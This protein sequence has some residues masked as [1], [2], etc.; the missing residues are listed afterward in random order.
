MAVSSS[1]PLTYTTDAEILSHMCVST[2]RHQLHLDRLPAPALARLMAEELRGMRVLSL[3][4][5]DGA[6]VLAALP[7]DVDMPPPC[8][9]VRAYRQCR[10]QGGVLNDRSHR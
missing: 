3:Y 6:F 7:T 9:I 5:P 1:L 8:E 4:W 10:Q 2:D